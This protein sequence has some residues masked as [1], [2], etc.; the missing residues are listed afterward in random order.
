MDES[1]FWELIERSRDKKGD[2]EK[3]AEALA[4]LLA[5]LPATEIAD[6]HDLLLRKVWDAYRWDLW[7]MAYIIN[8]GCSDDGFLY[9][10][11]WIVSQGRDVYENALHNPESLG[12]VA[13]PN[14]FYENELILYA[15][16]DAY[17]K[18]AN[19]KLESKGFDLTSDPEGE[20]WEEDALPDLYP[21]LCEKFG[22]E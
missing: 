8:A 12:E 21:E 18:V 15:A 10:R 9:F 16:L 11:G 14:E 19:K 7:A 1:K 17:E 20:R 2:P 4:N 13:E 5:K 22:M 3:H 6:F